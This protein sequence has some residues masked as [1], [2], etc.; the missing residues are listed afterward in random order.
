[1]SS[2]LEVKGLRGICPAIVTPLDENDEFDAAAMRRIVQHQLGAGVDGFYVC[3]GTGEGLLLTV[4]EREA[5][6]ET[7]LDEA[8]GRATVIA[9]VCAFHTADTLALTRHASDAGA[10]AVAAMP[11]AFFYKPD[12]LGLVR[13]YTAVAEASR[14]PVLVYNIPGRTGIKMTTEL[15]EELTS[16]DKIVGMKDAS[17]DLYQMSLFFS[18]GRKPIILN[19]EDT[20]MLGALLAGACGG[21]GATYNMMPVGS[22]DGA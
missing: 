9:H 22:G 8:G 7:V 3:G 6:L 11:P 17:A 21:V 4:P 10:D 20:V 14:V 1:M 5:A 18:G 2:D 12:E 16:I 15:F 13:Y 19:G